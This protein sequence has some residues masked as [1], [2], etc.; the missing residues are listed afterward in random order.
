MA[1]AVYHTLPLTGLV[2]KTLSHLRHWDLLVA[3]GAG[4]LPAGG[5]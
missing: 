3:I 2:A 1:L 4:G 5:W